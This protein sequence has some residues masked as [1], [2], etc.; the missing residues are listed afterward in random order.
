M[1]CTESQRVDMTEELSLHSTVIFS[2]FF[3]NIQIIYII[4]HSGGHFVNLYSQ[5]FNNTHQPLVR[6][7]ISAS[8]RDRMMSKKKK[9]SC[10]HAV[11]S[12][13]WETNNKCMMT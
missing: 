4:I 6:L 7:Y 2:G 13:E 3:W 5:L 8:S 9:F 11:C 1:D 12:R 10:S